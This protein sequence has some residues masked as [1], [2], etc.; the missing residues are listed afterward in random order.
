[1][2]TSGATYISVIKEQTWKK[3]ARAQTLFTECFEVFKN[4]IFCE[5][6]ETLL[7]AH[8]KFGDILSTSLQC[9]VVYCSGVHGREE[10]LGVV[11]S[12]VGGLLLF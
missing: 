4:Q 6:V 12:Y 8:D 5:I 1:M 9:R 10:Q 2:I 3:V 11:Q 7:S